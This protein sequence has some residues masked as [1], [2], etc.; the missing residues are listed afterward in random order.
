VTPNI[1]PLRQVRKAN[2]CLCGAKGDARHIQTSGPT[3]GERLRFNADLLD[4]V[5]RQRRL[6][7]PDLQGLIADLRR[8]AAHADLLEAA[9]ETGTAPVKERRPLREV[10]A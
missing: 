10:A 9:P 7:W 8:D 6:E 4:L 3:L 5:V 2:S 1:A